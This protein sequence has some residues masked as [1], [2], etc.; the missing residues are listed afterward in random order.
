MRGTAAVES[1]CSPFHDCSHTSKMSVWTNSSYLWDHRR[2]GGVGPAVGRGVRGTLGTRLERRTGGCTLSQLRK[3]TLRRLSGPCA[4]VSSRVDPDIRCT[5]LPV[6]R[7]GSLLPLTSDAGCRVGEQ[8]RTSVACLVMF[9]R[10]PHVQISPC[11]SFQAG[12]PFPLQGPIVSVAV[13][14]AQPTM[15]ATGNADGGTAL[16][17]LRFGSPPRRCPPADAAAGAVRQVQ[18]LAF[19]GSLPVP[20]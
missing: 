6:S 13:H 18:I 2:L 17:D 3:P 5:L 8:S 20:K 7:A 1:I 9:I 19:L 4:C 16:W 15:A 10:D 12:V 11:H 14:P